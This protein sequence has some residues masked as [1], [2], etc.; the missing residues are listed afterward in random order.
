[1]PDIL[2]SHSFTKHQFIDVFFEIGEKRISQTSA[3]GRHS[4]IGH[5]LFMYLVIDQL[6]SS[7]RGMR[8]NNSTYPV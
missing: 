5:I 4:T 6:Y 8:A 3:Q 1:M 7:T 2:F